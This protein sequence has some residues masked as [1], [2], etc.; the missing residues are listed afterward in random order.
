MDCEEQHKINKAGEGN[1]GMKVI[2]RLRASSA[3][4]TKFC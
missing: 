4:G 1:Y 3:T 2:Y